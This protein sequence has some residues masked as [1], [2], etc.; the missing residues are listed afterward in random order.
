V[1]KCHGSSWLDAVAWAKEYQ[2]ERL[3]TV[4]LA[5]KKIAVDCGID[6]NDGLLVAY[7][8]KLDA[9]LQ[10]AYY[11]DLTA[12]SIDGIL[13]DVTG[14]KP[15]RWWKVRGAAGDLGLALPDI[16]HACS[17]KDFTSGLARMFSPPYRGAKLYMRAYSHGPWICIEQEQLERVYAQP[18]ASNIQAPADIVANDGN[19]LVP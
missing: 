4:S 1:V 7:L 16:S 5:D 10:E 12:H 8:P 2:K 11:D 6:P 17:A 15:V 18:A 9:V 3:V 13:L 14:P 19:S